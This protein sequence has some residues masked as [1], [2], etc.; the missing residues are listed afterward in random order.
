MGTTMR[1]EPVGSPTSLLLRLTLTQVRCWQM[2]KYDS[3]YW[4]TILDPLAGL[5][6]KD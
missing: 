4:I 5:F 3:S 2:Q 6:G 1:D